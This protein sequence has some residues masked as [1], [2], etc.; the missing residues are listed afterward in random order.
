MLSNRFCVGTWGCFLPVIAKGIFWFPWSLTYA[1]PYRAIDL[2]ISNR[3]SSKNSGCGCTALWPVAS[4]LNI[5]P[6]FGAS[7]MSQ[8]QLL[9]CVFEKQLWNSSHISNSISEW[10]HTRA[11]FSLQ[12]VA[13]SWTIETNYVSDASSGSHATTIYTRPAN[14]LILPPSSWLM[15]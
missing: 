5:L 11:N 3:L 6:E 15:K 7:R 9:V 12:A 10:C 13:I 8:N 1:I 2:S 4:I 14:L